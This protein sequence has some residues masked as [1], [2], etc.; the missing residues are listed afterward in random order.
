MRKKIIF[1]AILS[2]SIL[3]SLQFIAPVNVK[4]SELQTAEDIK[5]RIEELGKLLDND[6]NIVQLIDMHKNQEVENIFTQVLEAE[7]NGEIQIL[8]N[9]Y[10][11]LLGKEQLNQIF[12]NINQ[13]YNTG[14]NS[15][16]SSLENLFGNSE[17]NSNIYRVEQVEG[18]LEIKKLDEVELKDNT[19]I[20]KGNC[21]FADLLLFSPSARFSKNWD[22]NKKTMPNTKPTIP[23]VKPA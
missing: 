1:G 5:E 15:V 6:Q 21:L 13:D 20:F 7:T 16:I 17:G 2:A 22:S 18:K 19:L 23:S 3:I 9:Q 12:E 11:D 14:L 10:V 4:A 8:A